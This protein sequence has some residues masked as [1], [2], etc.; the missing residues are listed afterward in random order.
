MD[1][2]RHKNDHIWR[3]VELEPRSLFFFPFLRIPTI[4]LVV[5][6]NHICALIDSGCNALGIFNISPLFL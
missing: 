3:D 4:K 2:V 5:M 1:V 6:S